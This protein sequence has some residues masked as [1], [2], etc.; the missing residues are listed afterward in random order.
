MLTIH[1]AIEFSA[2]L[3]SAASR[4]LSESPRWGCATVSVVIATYRRPLSLL[5][6]LR[7]LKEQSQ[8]P[9]EII[10]VAWAGDDMSVATLASISG[11]RIVYVQDNSVTTKENA[12]IA[13]ATTDV[14]AFID[15][16]A[17]ARHD[18]LESLR[19]YYTDP[20][21]VGVGGRDVVSHE[22]VLDD[23]QAA[24][25]GRIRW[26]GRLAGNHHLRTSG[27]RDVRFLKGCNMSFRRSVIVP[28][29]CRLLG[30][31]PYGYEIDMGLYAGRSGRIVYD[32]L[33]TVDHYSTS[34][35]N[36]INV[37][38]ATV[39]NHN[40]TYVL[41]KHLNWFGRVSFLVYTFLVGD[42]DTIGLFRVPALAVKPHWTASVL[43]A[44][45]GG[46]V[47]GV[48]SFLAWFRS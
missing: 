43:A 32:P 20:S 35:M 30:N 14:V 45:F 39:T 28:V 15:D 33:V 1:P 10:V 23:R 11:V 48:R 8:P 24:V 47:A 44:H 36:P 29:D 42:R 21:I 46:K 4:L 6:T 26:F 9:E 3:E 31:P 40:Q 13:A 7:S 25:I 12:G 37:S 5:E 19:R 38:L 27:A 34:D 41:L 17:V 16:D 22:G 18:W 2:T